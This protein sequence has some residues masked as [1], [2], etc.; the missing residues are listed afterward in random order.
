MEAEEF[1]HSRGRILVLCGHR[2]RP[3]ISKHSSGDDNEVLVIDS[4]ATN[5]PEE[6]SSHKYTFNWIELSLRQE[7]S[8]FDLCVKVYPRAWVAA[9]TAFIADNTRM[10]LAHDESKQFYVACRQ[11]KAQPKPVEDSD[12]LTAGIV[13]PRPEPEEETAMADGE[14]ERFARLRLYFWRY[15]NWRQRLK[16]LAQ[17]DLLPHTL[18][19][20]VPQTMERLALD[21]ARSQKKLPDLW[22]AVME[23]VPEDKRQ[24]N[25][26]TTAAK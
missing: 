12:R 16:I 20:P 7:D 18:D 13:E 14:E 4:G 5:P 10:E 11:F 26:F 17:L 21:A 6:S 3:R 23:L 24:V 2:H 19:R 1:L 8:R 15:L 22:T 9:R 25:P